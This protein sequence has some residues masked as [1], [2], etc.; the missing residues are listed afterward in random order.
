MIKIDRRGID[1]ALF[2][3]RRL[4]TI[5]RRRE[6]RR[7][8]TRIKR[9]ISE[10]QRRGGSLPVFSPLKHF[11][12]VTDLEIGGVSFY[13]DMLIDPS[14]VGP[15]GQVVQSFSGFTF[16]VFNA[17]KAA[18]DA[19]NTD[20]QA[21]GQS[22][23]FF[24]CSIENTQYSYQEDTTIDW[25]P[26]NAGS[27][28][29]YGTGSDATSIE[30]TMISGDLFNI[31][32]L[33]ND[34]IV[35]FHHLELKTDESIDLIQGGGSTGITLDNCWLRPNDS[36]AKAIDTGNA[37]VGWN[38][39]NTNIEGSGV[40]IGRTG[41]GLM[42]V[43]LTTCY[44]AVTTGIQL[45]NDAQVYCT[46]VRFNCTD[47]D[48]EIGATT[49]ALAFSAGGCEFNEGIYFTSGASVS[50]FDNFVVGTCVFNL[51]S[52]ET[53][54][55]YSGATGAGALLNAA[56]HSITSNTF[57]GSGTAKGIV[58]GSALADG[59]HHVAVGF[60]SFE[61]FTAG[62]EI[63]DMDLTGDNE[64]AHNVTDS[65]AVLMTVGAGHQA[66]SISVWVADDAQNPSIG[67][68]PANSFVVAVHLH[69]TEAFDSDGTDEIEVGYGADNNAYAT[70]TDVSTTGV[71]A[72][73]LGVDEGYS[74]T[75]R[76]AEAYYVNGGSEPTVGK[77]LVVIEFFRVLAEVA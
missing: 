55:D 36:G 65:G 13:F 61:G 43:R 20:R 46:N 32:T 44:V 2:A 28:H 75:E 40:G 27:Y 22:T 21:T 34:S 63:I 24:I 49:G 31:P 72:V 58:G 73:T 60:N 54:I 59:P 18:A 1:T 41:A 66:D 52:G 6:L 77:A 17:I 62:N 76:A 57:R 12:E 48:V 25:D 68:I 16:R 64:V 42:S 37:G 15:Q 14:W 50:W 67:V 5:A 53:G 45:I 7:V 29:V 8:Q 56:A 39:A 9:D 47:E 3:E 51:G 23:S 33:V 30:G 71:K 4:E 26:P 35:E 74:G 38:I 69:V 19:A 70:L 10:L 11:H